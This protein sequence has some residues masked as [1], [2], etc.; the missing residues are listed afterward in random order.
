MYPAKST[1]PIGGGTSFKGTVPPITYL[2]S[3]VYRFKAS[4]AFVAL[5]RL[6]ILLLLRDRFP[7][8]AS[9]L[10]NVVVFK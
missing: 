2:A 5:A 10:F 3:A 7:F 9:K 1:F 6:V 4:V 8:G